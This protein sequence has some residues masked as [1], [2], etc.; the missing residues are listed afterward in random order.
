MLSFG[1]RYSTRADKQGATLVLMDGAS[2]DDSCVPYKCIS[3]DVYMMTGPLLQQAEGSEMQ[4]VFD[5]VPT[6]VPRFGMLDV[7][8]VPYEN[9]YRT[10]ERSHTQ[11]K[12]QNLRVKS[13]R[14]SKCQGEVSLKDD[15]C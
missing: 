11:P 4:A 10:C 3:I 6:R 13:I 14:T 12:Y 5:R 2:Q 8:C 15:V 7:T 9:I 1:G